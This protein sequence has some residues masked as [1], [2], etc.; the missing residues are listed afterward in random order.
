MLLIESA[1]C[2]PAFYLRADNCSS[3][4]LLRDDWS[5]VVVA[6][7]VLPESHRLLLDAARAYAAGGK[8][9]KLGNLR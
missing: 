4:S 9:A 2:D 7:L 8:A 3:F 5:A 6:Q 1:V